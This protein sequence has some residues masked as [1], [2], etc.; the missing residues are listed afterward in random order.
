[1]GASILAQQLSASEQLKEQ[2]I[3]ILKQ[4]LSEMT[5][6]AGAENPHVTGEEI[7]KRVDALTSGAAT[8]YSALVA[9][10]EHEARRLLIVGPDDKDNRTAM[11]RN[12]DLWKKVERPMPTLYKRMQDEVI[13]GEIAGGLE[14]ELTRRISEFHLRQL[15][16]L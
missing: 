1:V 13:T 10:P 7:T 11:Q 5:A 14:L 2:F 6:K 12:I 3:A 16:L 8:A 15:G 4:Q 9:L